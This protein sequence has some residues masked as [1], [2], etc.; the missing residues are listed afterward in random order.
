MVWGAVLEQLEQLEPY[1]SQGIKKERNHH[2]LNTGKR[3]GVSRKG[4]KPPPLTTPKRKRT[5][6]TLQQPHLTRCEVTLYT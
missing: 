5:S 6:L 1:T 4:P 2:A 3:S